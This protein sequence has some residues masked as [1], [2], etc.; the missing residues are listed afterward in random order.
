M[1]VLAIKTVKG[2]RVIEDSQILVSVFRTFQ[3][4]IP[5]IPRARARRTDKIS[6]TIGWKWI[7]VIGEVSF[8]GPAAL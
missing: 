1:V 3:I 4:G 5:G 6:H 7:M 8:K 2:T